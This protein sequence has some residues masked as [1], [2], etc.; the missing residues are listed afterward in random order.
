MH[1]QLTS[2]VSAVLN[3]NILIVVKVLECIHAST[4]ERR[5]P[6]L[7]GSLAKGK[8]FRCSPSCRPLPSLPPLSASAH[9]YLSPLNTSVDMG[10]PYYHQA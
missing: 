4:V 3:V 6:Q 1:L 10:A 9:R 5:L 7:R 2:F 8:G